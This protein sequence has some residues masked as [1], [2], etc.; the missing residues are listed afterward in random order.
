MSK[1]RVGIGPFLLWVAANLLGWLVLVALLAALP[2]LKSIR[3]LFVAPLLIGV[4]L[5]IAQWL[6][7]RRL[8]PLSPLWVLT[9]P[10]GWVLSM[11]VPVAIPASLWQ[12]V[13]S[14]STATL[15]L[16]YVVMGAVMGLPQ[17]LML[18]R[19]LLRAAWWILGNSVGMGL[20]FA[21]VLVTG[22]IN[23]SEFWSYTAVVLVYGIATGAILLWLLGQK[24]QALN[25]RLSAA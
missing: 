4:P 8:I 11:L 15:T 9:L 24:A 16:L 19:K 13:D 6:V 2:T 12:V 22:F 18:R 25:P 21:L 17:W 23:R 14:E 20:G 5:G 1:K 10:V 7:L 3:G